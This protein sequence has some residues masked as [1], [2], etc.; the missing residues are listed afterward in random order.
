MPNSCNHKNMEV[1]IFANLSSMRPENK[2]REMTQAHVCIH[3][4]CNN[5]NQ[6]PDDDT[7]NFTAKNDTRQ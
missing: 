5:I 7:C 2:Q 1:V 4:P 6:T 3:A